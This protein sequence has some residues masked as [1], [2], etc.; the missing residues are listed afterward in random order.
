MV[1][2]QLQYGILAWGLETERIYV[3]QKRAVRVV[4]NSYFIAHSEPLFKTLSLLRIDDLYQLSVLKFYYKL[5]NDLLPC[6]FETFKSAIPQLN[7]NNI[8][9]GHNLRPRRLQLPR[10]KHTFATRCLRYQLHCTIRETS[11][12]ILEKISTHSLKGF[13]WYIKTTYVNKYN[14]TCQLRFCYVCRRGAVTYK[15]ILF[16]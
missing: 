16:L 14:E 15:I 4:T 9:N 5:A 1:L 7:N 2:P 13:S 3:L 12:Q 11:E 10:V 8:S 6:Y